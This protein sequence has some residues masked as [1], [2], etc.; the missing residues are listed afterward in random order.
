MA[1]GKASPYLPC[2]KTDSDFCRAFILFRCEY[3]DVSLADLG[4][5]GG[6]DVSY[7]REMK[8]E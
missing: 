1:K 8:P 7:P 6:S 4:S 3:W 5:Q 2:A